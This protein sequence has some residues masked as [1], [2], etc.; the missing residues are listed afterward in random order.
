MHINGAELR[1]MR[2][3]K[4]ITLHDAAKTI[5]LKSKYLHELENDN[6]EAY[7]PEVYVIGYKRSYIEFL[8]CTQ[9]I[10]VATNPPMKDAKLENEMRPIT[11]NKSLERLFLLL[12]SLLGIFVSSL[13]YQFL[14]IYK[15]FDGG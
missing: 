1:K 7:L 3:D 9:D 15:N 4:G 10:N 2:E 5:Y 6:L 8:D 11:T 13:L 12:L 14:V